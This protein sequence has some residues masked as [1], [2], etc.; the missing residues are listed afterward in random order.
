[1]DA[2]EVANTT[3]ER[4]RQQAQ[5]APLRG[6]GAA[7]RQRVRELELLVSVASKRCIEAKRASDDLLTF[8]TEQ[9]G[10]DHV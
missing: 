9:E 1:M 5:Q 6:P 8:I 2:L 7:P 3:L 4:W 10:A